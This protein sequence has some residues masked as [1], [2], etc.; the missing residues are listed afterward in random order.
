MIFVYLVTTV[1]GSCWVARM[2]LEKRLI[3]T[4]SFW[5]F[6]LLLFL[7][8]IALS[9][10]FSHDIYM[11]LFGY[12][13]RFN[14]GFF[15][16][17]AYFI[18]Y[19][20]FNSNIMDS[21]KREKFIKL[22]IFA[23]VA[24]GLIV[25][26]YGICQH[27]GIDYFRWVQDVK[28]R[29]FSSLGQPNWL[30]AYLAIILLIYFGL[31]VGNTFSLLPFTLLYTALLFTRSRSAFSAFHI[32][33]LVFTVILFKKFKKIF[34]YTYLLF[35]ILVNVFNI[36]PT[37]IEKINELTIPNLISKISAISKSPGKPQQNKSI[38]Q[39]TAAVASAGEGGTESFAIRK[40][41]WKGAW[42]AYLANPI[43]GYGNEAF[44]LAYYKYKPIEQNYVSEW[45]FLYNK[46]HNEYLNYLATTGTVGFGAYLLLIISFVVYFIR[47]PKNI[48]NLSLF[49]AWLTILITNFVGFS[50]V[51]ISLFFYLIPP[52]I[53]VLNINNKE[54][55][56]SPRDEKSTK[57]SNNLTIP[58]LLLLFFLLL[59][60]YYVIRNTVSWW[61]A[62]YHFARGD[63]YSNKGN[64]QTSYQEYKSAIDL[65][66]FHPNYHN[67]F[68]LFLSEMPSYYSKDDAK[69]AAGFARQAIEESD[70]ATGISPE[71][72]IFWNY[73]AL[74][75]HN[76]VNF[77]K[78]YSKKAIE[79]IMKAK[80][81]AP[82]DPKIAYYA[83]IYYLSD[84]QS[85]TGTKYLTQAVSLKPNY[86][87]PAVN[88]SRILAGSGEN[89]KA[90]QIL[91]NLLK[92]YPGNTDIEKQ[93]ESYQTK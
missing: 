28:T 47:S 38:V 78:N 56:Q 15:S 18:L 20:A 85:K 42:N 88:L 27:F 22:I 77:D 26:L 45:D 41:V 6:P 46:A 89:G 32:C 86:I 53:F 91:K 24:S 65:S 68:A 34:V 70:I 60:T 84:G 19:F 8:A 11:S 17:L 13:S 82:N 4:K 81:L 49:L 44:A 73:K 33:F 52:I 63:S 55:L 71:N 36:L 58:Q 64:Y 76:L 51:I 5:D 21:V 83:G 50:V 23:A 62:D 48:L 29:V 30:G 69:L 74:I 66:P 54:E 40:N 90:I 1:I 79:A 10:L 9:T 37:P 87:E 12:Y 59:T 2:T 16:L 14:Q 43:V 93:I 31:F 67:E 92:Y 25:S 7:T 35:F 61:F 57:Q 72:P 39:P 75:F 3:F 80:S